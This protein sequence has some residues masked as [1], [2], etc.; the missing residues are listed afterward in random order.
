MTPTELPLFPLST[1]LLPGGRLDLRI[2]ERRYLDMVRDC[3]RSGGVFGVCLIVRGR[4]SGEP[5]VPAAFGT[6]ARIVD[7]ST[8]PDGLLG[9]TA[10][11]EGRFHVA[12]NR[13]RDNGLIIGQVECLPADPVLPVPPEYALLATILE[14]IAE[15][16]GG[17]LGGAAK[18]RFD[19]AA[20][21][22]WRLAD[23]LPLDQ[24]ERQ[25]LL[26]DPDP[27]HRLELLAHWL[28]RFQR[29]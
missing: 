17:E 14:R 3:S 22:A 27:A 20:W 26:Q 8:L 25:Q 28:P 16:V 15:Q 12:R 21:V 6:V 4:E 1:V 18:E 5:A 2:F 9:I 13:V 19:D 7:F 29:H 11:G 23:L 24:E 10:R